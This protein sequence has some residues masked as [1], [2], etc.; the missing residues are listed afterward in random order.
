MPRKTQRGNQ[1]RRNTTHNKRKGL[2]RTHKYKTLKGGLG[3]NDKDN[4]NI[5]DRIIFQSECKQ[6]GGGGDHSTRQEKITDF[7]KY[8]FGSAEHAEL[9]ET[10]LQLCFDKSIPF[11]ILTSGSKIG[12]I[13]TL[14]LLELDD[15]V[16][17]VLCNNPS[18]DTNPINIRERD[19]EYFKKM[20]KYQIIESIINN[21]LSKGIFV[22][23]DERNRENSELC[24]NI[25][26]KHAKGIQIDRFK[27]EYQTRFSSFVTELSNEY[28]SPISGFSRTFYDKTH[29]NLVDEDILKQ[30][31]QQI[32]Q[33]ADIR[34]MFA[35]FDGTMSPWRGALPFHI[36]RFNNRFYSHFNVVEHSLL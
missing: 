27:P 11:Y 8:L 21:R 15:F 34:F 30:I 36:Q 22:D 20:N 25:E 26:F 7:K 33:D 6:I 24:P 13:R 4:I 18:V 19:R 3:D 10:I 31:I 32:E 5:T 16:A 14:Q 1:K 35:D 23:N 29:S 9:W 12:I 2:K 17:E 28:K